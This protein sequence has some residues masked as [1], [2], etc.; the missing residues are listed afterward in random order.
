[1]AQ[2]MESYPPI[3]EEARD[4]PVPQPSGRSEVTKASK[5]SRLS[6]RSGTTGAVC[7][8]GARRGGSTG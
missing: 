3:G 7:P 1:M 8:T 6:G 4:L 2:Q 5:G